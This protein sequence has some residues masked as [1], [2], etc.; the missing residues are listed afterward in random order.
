MI[1]TVGD[2]IVGAQNASIAAQNQ[3]LRSSNNP[4]QY[5]YPTKSHYTNVSF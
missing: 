3:T 2:L 1:R 5:M 4:N